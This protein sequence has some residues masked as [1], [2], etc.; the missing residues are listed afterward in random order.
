MAPA[1]T[2]HSERP[3]DR[4]ERQG[5]VSSFF[6]SFL[7]LLCCLNP[8][9]PCALAVIRL[10]RGGWSKETATGWSLGF[11]FSFAAVDGWFLTILIVLRLACYS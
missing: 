2:V 8:P 10:L 7:F 6:F 9:L 4:E 3:I 11:S 1:A 5:L